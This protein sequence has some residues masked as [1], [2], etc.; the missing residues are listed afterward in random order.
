MRHLL[1]LTSFSGLLAV[2]MFTPI[3]YIVPLLIYLH[4]WF[5]L[6]MN[7]LIMQQTIPT[8][9][10]R[11]IR[12]LCICLF[13]CFCYCCLFLFCFVVWSVGWVFCFVFVFFVCFDWGL[14]LLLLLL[15]CLFVCL[16][17]GGVGQTE[18]VS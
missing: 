12:F 11:F 17:F 5:T 6:P 8:T 18:P 4:P 3:N 10:H 13:V 15:F 16:F 7:P 14:L 2:S 1:P 9:E